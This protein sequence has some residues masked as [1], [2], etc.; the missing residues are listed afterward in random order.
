MELAADQSRGGGQ[1]VGDGFQAGV[2]GVAMWVA[3]SA[4]VPMRFHAGDADAEVDQPFPPRATEGVGDKNGNGE[5]GAGLKFTMKFAGGAVGI[6]GQEKRVL[7][8]IYV[9]DVH[10]AVSA[11][12]TV[13][14]LGNQH[15]VFA[16]NDGAA[17]AQGQ[18][19]DASVYF[20]FPGPCERMGRRFNRCQIDDSA[21]RFG[22]DFMFDNEDVTRFEIYVE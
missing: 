8:A 15:T 10:A 4:I 21:F 19:D 18:F 14:R 2:Q 7:S 3:V 5:R 9:G 16:P 11:D 1:F 17:L 6:G 13:A 20:V 22:N 12:E